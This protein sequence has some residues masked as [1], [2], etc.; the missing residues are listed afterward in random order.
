MPVSRWRH[1]QNAL[2]VSLAAIAAAGWL[3]VIY[4]Q[5]KANSPIEIVKKHFIFYPEYSHGAW[6]DAPCAAAGA[7]ECR[8]VTY[9]IALKGCGAVDLHWQVFPGS[10]DGDEAWSYSGASPRIDDNRYPL[11]A[12]LNEDSRLIDSPALGKPAPDAC[13]LK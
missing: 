10:G 4:N 5:R 11:F 9:S 13:E 3:Y 2:M 6:R 1:V 12:V 8:E 7:A